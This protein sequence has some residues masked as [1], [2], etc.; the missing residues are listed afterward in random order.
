MIK[1]T[2]N[3]E[4]LEKIKNI[5]LVQLREVKPSQVSFNLI[6]ASKKTAML[7]DLKIKI[8]KKK[9]EFSEGMYCKKVIE[10]DKEAEKIEAHLYC[11]ES[12]EEFNMKIKMKI[13]FKGKFVSPIIQIDHTNMDRLFL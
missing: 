7:S 3:N 6:R 1:A 12:I 10:N 8:E 13:R 5:E 9:N 11:L 4:I 2:M